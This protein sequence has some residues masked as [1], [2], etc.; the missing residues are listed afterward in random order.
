MKI[1][2][3]NNYCVL[4]LT[5]VYDVRYILCNKEKFYRKYTTNKPIIQL[6]Q[7]T[8]DSRQRQ[9]FVGTPIVHIVGLAQCIQ[10]GSN[11]DQLRYHT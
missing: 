2:N 8:S 7:E 1:V 10:Q 5:D 3:E 11:T 6:S 9:D 4:L